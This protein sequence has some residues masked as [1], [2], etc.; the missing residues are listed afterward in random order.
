MDSHF[1]YPSVNYRYH[2]YKIWVEI[3]EYMYFSFLVGRIIESYK[4]PFEKG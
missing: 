1:I 2:Y 4:K 3:S